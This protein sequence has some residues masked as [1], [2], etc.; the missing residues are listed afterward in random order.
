M[1][2]AEA[3]ALGVVQKHICKVELPPPI[4]VNETQF[5]EHLAGCE[6]CSKLYRRP[7]AEP[8]MMKPKRPAKRGGVG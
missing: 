3:Y 8:Q 5:A 2:D 1:L 6:A 7:E 4:Q